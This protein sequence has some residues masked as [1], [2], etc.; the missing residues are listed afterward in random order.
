[1]TFTESQV[2]QLKAGLRRQHVRERA[3]PDGKVLHYL[4][5]WRVV[6]EANRIFGFDGWDRETVAT[7]CVWQKQTGSGYAV[8]YLTRV[9]VSVRAGFEVI[10]REGLGSGEATAATPG[11]AHEMAAKSAETDATKRALSTFGNPFG[12]SLYRGQA[13]AKPARGAERAEPAQRTAPARPAEQA[14]P[15]QPIEAPAPAPTAGPPVLL[16]T[17]EMEDA[18]LPVRLP[19]AGPPLQNATG[20]RIEKHT[21]ALPE[22]RRQRDLEHLR[23]VARQPC[24]A[25][26]RTPSQAHHLRFTQPRAMARKVSDEFTVPLCATHHHELHLRGD[27]KGW[28]AER[29]IDPSPIA[30][31]LWR[32]SRTGDPG[33][34]D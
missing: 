5:G 27:E 23:F 18:V 6:A 30:E 21:L 19:K 13:E 31:E 12:L 14:A 7:T 33:V 9:R 28:W 17:T 26:G 2:R 22:P 1:M 8:A 34:A 3:A 29:A 15:A 32:A 16:S 11:Q 20:L 24:L 10:L 25:C 4:E